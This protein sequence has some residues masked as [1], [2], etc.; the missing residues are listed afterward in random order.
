MILIA[1]LI[2]GFSSHYA[3]KW[4]KKHSGVLYIASALLALFTVAAIWSPI[5]KEASDMGRTVLSLLTNATLSGALFLMV[6]MAGAL[7]AGSLLMREWMRLRAELSIIAG[8]LTFGHNIA[9]GKTYFVYLFGDRHMLSPN[10]LIAAIIS[11]LMILLLF[12]LWLTSFRA[13]R[14]HMKTSTWKRLQKLAY[15]FYFLLYI[16]VLLLVG[17]RALEGNIMHIFSFAVYTLIYIAY[18]CL[19]VKKHCRKSSYQS[20]ILGLCLLLMAVASAAL[21][22]TGFALHQSSKTLPAAADTA[23]VQK[24]EDNY[25][26]GV[27][28]GKGKGY[29][30]DISVEIEILDNS[31]RRIEVLRHAEDEP[32]I[33]WAINAYIPDIIKTQSL[34]IDAVSEATATCVGIRRA[35]QQAL[36]KAAEE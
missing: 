23:I 14:R 30:D 4:I 9:F 12:P 8:I 22:H 19:K 11:I 15:P 17:V 2:A 10:V 13:I 26:D 20:L 32:Y 6:M 36:K 21:L 25:R 31:I 24:L 5:Y 34:D 7:P 35:V 3:G 18:I 16:H 28:E 1:L 29:N 27:Y 33:Y